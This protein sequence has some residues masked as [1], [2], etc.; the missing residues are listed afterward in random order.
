MP[1]RLVGVDPFRAALS[2][3]IQLARYFYEQIQKI[4]GF[5]VGPYPDLSIM[6]Y[7]YL[8]KQGNAD[9]FNHRLMQ[10]IQQDGRVF[11]SA[12]RVDRKFVLRLAVG[13]FRT[14]L[15]DIEETLK[16]LRRTAKQLAE[17]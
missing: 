7:Q 9:A 3:K 2:E 4:E 14:Y 11:I 15:E 13:C 6:T 17:A 8:P 16:I 12:T 5:E 10:T 1:L